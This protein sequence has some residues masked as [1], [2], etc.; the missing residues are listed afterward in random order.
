MRLVKS[1]ASASIGSICVAVPIEVCCPKKFFTLK[2]ANIKA[3]IAFRIGET[4]GCINQLADALRSNSTLQKLD[5][6]V[7]RVKDCCWCELA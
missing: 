7:W 3:L 6:Q 5:L 2:Y 1:V 4:E